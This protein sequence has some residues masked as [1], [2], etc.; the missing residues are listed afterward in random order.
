MSSS[1][2]QT[3]PA[4]MGWVPQAYL[5]TSH[6]DGIGYFLAYLPM[7]SMH[8]LVAKSLHTTWYYIHTIRCTPLIYHFIASYA[9][10][11]PIYYLHAI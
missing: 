5:S 9:C 11:L 7:P 10:I 2:R 8:R 4:R 3:C 1:G 6:F